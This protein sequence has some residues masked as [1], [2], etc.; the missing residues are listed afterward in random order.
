M[1]TAHIQEQVR[2]RFNNHKYELFNAYVF[3]EGWESDFFSITSS[4]YCYEVE[5][6]ISRS[7]F[8]ADFKK[9]KHELFKRVHSGQQFYFKNCGPDRHGGEV[10][11]K[12]QVSMFINRGLRSW[13]NDEPDEH[14]DM[15]N[16]WR[17]WYLQTNIRDYTA[18][19]TSIKY[20]DLNKTHCPNRFYYAVPE[21][22]IKADEVPVYAGLIYVSGNNVRIIKEAPFLHKR[23]HDL[24]S[25]LADKFYWQTKRLKF[26]L[27]QLKRASQ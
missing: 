9:D 20:I 12:A 24:Y 14:R 25:I 27:E 2:I 15:L 1:T 26:E 23:K 6:K 4:G 21:P 13:M 18:P 5:V 19:C 3:N 11:C 22:L 16:Q 10:I 17:D 7:D 8:F